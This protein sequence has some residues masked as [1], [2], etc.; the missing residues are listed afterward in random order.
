MSIEYSGELGVHLPCLRRNC[1]HGTGCDRVTA[2][3]AEDVRNQ[4]HLTRYTRIRVLL[5]LQ[6]SNFSSTVL[7]KMGVRCSL[8]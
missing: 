5:Q 4:T 8:E 1:H 6:Q 3:A 7:D 2:A